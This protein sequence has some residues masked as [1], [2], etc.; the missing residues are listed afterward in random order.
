[1]TAEIVKIN[2]DNPDMRMV[3][4]VAEQIKKGHVTGVP[5][6]TFYGLAATTV[7]HHRLPKTDVATI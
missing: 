6:D 4:Y 2:P 1:M 7:E 3:S 5:T